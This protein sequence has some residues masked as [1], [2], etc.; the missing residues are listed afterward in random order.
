MTEEAEMLRMYSWY[1]RLPRGLWFKP[2]MYVYFD[3]ADAFGENPADL[4]GPAS[5]NRIPLLV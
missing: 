4:L 1:G 2:L 5:Q 3:T